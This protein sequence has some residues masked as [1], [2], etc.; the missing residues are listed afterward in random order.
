MPRPTVL[1]IF[2]FFAIALVIAGLV[3]LKARSSSTNSSSTGISIQVLQTPEVSHRPE[4]PEQAILRREQ[5]SRKFA[6]DESLILDRTRFD[7]NRVW[8]VAEGHLSPLDKT[9]DE[10]PSEGVVIIVRQVGGGD[11]SVTYPSD[12]DYEAIVRAVPESILSQEAKR[13]LIVY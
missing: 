6:A 13:F 10:A 7:S 12:S 2:S 4:G 9:T 8:F 3:L 1:A 11:W 5:S